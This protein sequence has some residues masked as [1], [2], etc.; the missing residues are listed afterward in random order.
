MFRFGIQYP[1]PNDNPL[2][3]ASNSLR[4]LLVVITLQTFALCWITYRLEC[5]V[6]FASQ[7]A[8]ATAKAAL[9]AAGL[10]SDPDELAR[11]FPKKIE[12]DIG[13]E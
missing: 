7:I 6:Q 12:T 5:G 3:T 2:I 4:V 13:D 8:A 11:R 10:P 1:E 9:E